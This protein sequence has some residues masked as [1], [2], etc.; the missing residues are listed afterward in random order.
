MNSLIVYP[1]LT[2]RLFNNK[3]ALKL[4]GIV[5]DPIQILLKIES[6]LPREWNKKLIDMN[7]RDL[8]D[9]EIC[10]ADHVFIIAMSDQEES[11]SKVIAK[12]KKLNAKV[13]A[14]GSLFTRSDEYY[15][16]VDHLVLDEA[17]IPTSQF[18]NDLIEGKQKYNS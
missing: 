18:L 16:N 3:Y 17:E 14:Y 10:Q 2:S 13:V 5:K 6:L 7:T 1:K 4:A 8:Q 15:R 11:T 9:E 12:C